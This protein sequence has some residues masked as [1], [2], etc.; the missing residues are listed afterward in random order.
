MR[1]TLNTA[2]LLFFLFAL[3][4][5]YLQ[6]QIIDT[7]GN[8]GV[9]EEDPGSGGRYP[10]PNPA[11]TRT[12][13]IHT[14]IPQEKG[15]WNYQ[16]ILVNYNAISYG[17]TK[18]L[19]L[20]LEANVLSW[21]LKQKGANLILSTKVGF[22][23]GRSLYAGGVLFM[24]TEDAQFVGN[25]FGLLTYGNLDNNLT[26]GIDYRVDGSGD[27]KALSRVYLGGM[28]RLGKRFGLLSENNVELGGREGTLTFCGRYLWRKATVWL[29]LLFDHRFYFDP[30]ISLEGPILGVAARF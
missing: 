13:I 5:L 21:V 19:S 6:A 17:I 11:G 14:A 1:K 18:N 20:G 7:I 15:E 25:G 12:L 16:N 27:M 29:G 10:F 23:V 3:L 4:P 2:T 30:A 28:L 26:M 9:I 24:G 22:P 8:W